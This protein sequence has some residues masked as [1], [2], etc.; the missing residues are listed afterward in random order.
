MKRSFTQNRSVL[1]RRSVREKT[2]LLNQYRRSGLSLLAFAQSH[3]LCYSTLIRWRKRFGQHAQSQRA[4][5][6][7][8]S[9][10][11]IPV[12]LEPEPAPGA[13]YVLGLSGGRSLKIPR[14]FETDSLRRL[15]AVLEGA[16]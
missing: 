8:P 10:K 6:V 4:P 14:Q 2:T 9:P 12:R 11:F 5:K 3:Q 16:Q 7:A 15:L 13:P 1:G